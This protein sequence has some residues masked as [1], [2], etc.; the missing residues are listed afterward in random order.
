MGFLFRKE[1]SSRQLP[2]RCRPAPAFSVLSAVMPRVCG[3][4]TG[5]Y[6]S[7]PKRLSTLGQRFVG[8]YRIS[9]SRLGAPPQ[10]VDSRL[11]HPRLQSRSLDSETGSCTLRSGDDPVG[12]LERGHNALPLGVVQRGAPVTTLA[13]LRWLRVT[14]RREIF[15]RDPQD[16][17]RRED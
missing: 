1:G 3:A 7:T 14:R 11:L 10:D 12:L 16:S 9:L 13:C 4:L 15:A 2:D 17:I 8:N 6:A 5:G